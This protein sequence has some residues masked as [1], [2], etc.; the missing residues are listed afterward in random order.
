MKG[1]RDKQENIRANYTLGTVWYYIYSVRFVIKIYAGARK[2]IEHDND[3]DSGLPTKYM[4]MK[5]TK[6]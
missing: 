5:K 6:I 4:R 2:D 1:L 3:S